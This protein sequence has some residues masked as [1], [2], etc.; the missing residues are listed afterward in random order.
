MCKETVMID[1][2]YYWYGLAMT[3]KPQI[4]QGHCGPRVGLQLLSGIL[5]GQRLNKRE[6]S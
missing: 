1:K 5:Q 2:E 6:Q 4:D 3:M